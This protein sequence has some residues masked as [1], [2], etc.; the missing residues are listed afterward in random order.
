MTRGV[1]TI[2]RI[3]GIQPSNVIIAI[4]P[5]I[6]LLAKYGIVEFCAFLSKFRSFEEK[7]IL[8]YIKKFQ[9]KFIKQPTSVVTTNDTYGFNHD[10]CVFDYQHDFTHAIV[11]L[12]RK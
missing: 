4:R 3:F 12:I 7:K 11:S 6:L 9:A 10:A 8:K 5:S 1:Y 2:Y